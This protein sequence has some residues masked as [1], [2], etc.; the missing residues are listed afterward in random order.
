MLRFLVISRLF[1]RFARSNIFGLPVLDEG[2]PS[3]LPL[4]SRCEACKRIVSLS[5]TVMRCGKNA[6]QANLYD[7]S[8]VRSSH[9][10][11]GESRLRNRFRVEDPSPIHD[12][13]SAHHFV[14]S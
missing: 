3:I 11:V 14:H 9:S 10:F 4:I 6:L 8:F 1:L 13:L 5:P 7:A 12:D 2:E